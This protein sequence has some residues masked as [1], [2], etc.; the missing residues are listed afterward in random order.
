ML[1]LWTVEQLLAPALSTD[2]HC[3]LLKQQGSPE[4]SLVYSMVSTEELGG[5]SQDRSCQANLIFL[6]KNDWFLKM[7]KAGKFSFLCSSDTSKLAVSHQPPFFSS[8]RVEHKNFWY[9]DCQYSEVLKGPLGWRAAWPE[10]CKNKGWTEITGDV[11]HIWILGN[12]SRGYE[13]INSLIVC[14]YV[15]CHLW[16]CLA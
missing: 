3:Q 6:C 11:K 9:R 14:M 7:R 8:T 16:V 4:Q 1:W 5:G 10:A 12:L 15:S 2:W 13:H